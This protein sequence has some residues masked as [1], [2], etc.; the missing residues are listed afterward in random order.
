MNAQKQRKNTTAAVAIIVLILLVVL[1]VGLYFLFTKPTTPAPVAPPTVTETP[2]V[3][4]PT[5]VAPAVTT[6]KLLGVHTVVRKDTLWWISDKWYK[7]PV[8][9]PSIYEINKAEIQDPDR[10]F[11]G[12]KFD[13]PALTGSAGNLSAEDKSLLAQGYLEAYRVYKEKGKK[14][15][16]DYKVASERLSATK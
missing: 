10:I 16:N 5:P 2:V 14:D 1:G 6:P 12:Q 3:P 11:P 4:D 8:L 13:I 9:W 15:A 7:D